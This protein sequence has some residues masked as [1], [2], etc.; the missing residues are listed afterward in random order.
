MKQALVLLFIAALFFSCKN[1]V[2][3]EKTAKLQTPVEGTWE[4]ISATT[5]V[6]ND[7]TVTDYT[8][9]LKMIKIING[10]HFAFLKHELNKGKDTAMYGSGG[11]SYTLADSL[12][13]EHLDFCDAREWEGHSFE[14]TVTAHND[15]LIQTGIEK[16]QN[17]GV[18][19]RIIEKYVRVKK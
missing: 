2:T 8:K 3:A 19:R 9:N 17:L 7:T 4:L 5:I 13:T 14:F 1:T 16:I 15:T 11:G 10:T 18:D 6:K 12:Y